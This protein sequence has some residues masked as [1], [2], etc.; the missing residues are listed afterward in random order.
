MWF[1]AKRIKYVHERRGDIKLLVRKFPVTFFYPSA[2]C[3]QSNIQSLTVFFM[4]PYIT[5]KNNWPLL[6]DGYSEAM[7][8]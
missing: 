2:D 3:T 1:F 6:R 5:S 8:N 4:G 7:I